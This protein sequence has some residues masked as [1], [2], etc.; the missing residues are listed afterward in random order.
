MKI[1]VRHE[2]GDFRR[3]KCEACG[4]LQLPKD[5]GRYRSLGNPEKSEVVLCLLPCGRDAEKHPTIRA[6]RVD[7]PI[8]T[9]G[10]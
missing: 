6:Y 2:P 1:T 5:A 4:A 10:E 7:G 3:A 8:I 9:H